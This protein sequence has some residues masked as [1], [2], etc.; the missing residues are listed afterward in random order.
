MK[1]ARHKYEQE[2]KS[3]DGE[4]TKTAH[5]V[6]E[7]QNTSKVR[8][9]PVSEMQVFVKCFNELTISLDIHPNDT[10]DIIKQKIEQSTG[11][12]AKHQGSIVIGTKRIQNGETLA[13]HNIHQHATLYMMGGLRGGV[14]PK[15]KPKNKRSKALGGVRDGAKSKKREKAHWGRYPAYTNGLDGNGELKQYWDT[16][17]KLPPDIG[18]RPIT[19]KCELCHGVKGHIGCSR[20][21]IIAAEAAHRARKAEWVA[22]KARN[23]TAARNA[24][25]NAK[26]KADIAQAAAVSAAASAAAAEPTEQNVD[27]EEA[28]ETARR[29]VARRDENAT[30]D[31]GMRHI[32]TYSLLALIITYPLTYIHTY[33]IPYRRL[34]FYA[35]PLT[36]IHTN[37]CT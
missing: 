30:T 23:T 7:E 9:L 36:H 3:H 28:E 33:Y 31:P 26:N 17:F 18:D 19:W 10:G 29:E 21:S 8:D 20:M 4:T 11:I 6:V 24:R 25:R 1:T 22:T 5:K 34:H 13:R 15:N 35:Y 14:A 12:L 27:E 16:N 2:K 32:Y 37:I